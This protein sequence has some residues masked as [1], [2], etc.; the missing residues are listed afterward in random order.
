MLNEVLLKD[1]E[2]NLLDEDV[3]DDKQG[4][5]QILFKAMVF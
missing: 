4:G 1:D 3:D 5:G 2:S